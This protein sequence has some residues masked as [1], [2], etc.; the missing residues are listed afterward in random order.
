MRLD[1]VLCGDICPTQS[2]VME[3]NSAG[4]PIYGTGPVSL[5]I[6]LK[7]ASIKN[8]MLEDCLYIPG[9]M[10]SL[11]SWSKLKSLN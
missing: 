9:L 2:N 8:I 7:N 3:R 6:V 1:I 4:I 5:F 10:K 11:F